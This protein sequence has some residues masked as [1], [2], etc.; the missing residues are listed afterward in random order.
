VGERFDERLLEALADAGGGHFRFLESVDRVG[1]VMADE[2]EEMLS[3]SVRD[4]AVAVTAPEGVVVE[5]LDGLPVSAS[6]G[7]L[8]VS[9]GDLVGDQVV[10]LVLQLRFP[11]GESG[12]S[13][14]VGF[15]L[16]DRGELLSGEAQRSWTWAD[17]AAND[18]QDRDGEVD[19]AV[20]RA[21]AERARAEAL[22]LNASGDLRGGP[23][24]LRATAR[25]I[26]SYAGRDQELNGLVQTLEAEAEDYRAPLEPMERRERHYG[27][28]R[29]RRG[30]DARGRAQRRP[31]VPDLKEILSSLRLGA[32]EVHQNL[33]MF[34]LTNG[35]TRVPD[36][37]TFAEASTAGTVRVEE[38]SEGGSVPELRVVNEGE[39]PVL[40]LD[41]EELIGAKQNRIVNLTILCPA[42]HT[43]VVPVS[44]VEAGRWS[45]SRPDFMDSRQALFAEARARKTRDVNAALRE[46]G[47]RRTDQQAVWADIET[48]ARHLK[49][50]SR[51]SAMSDMYEQQAGVIEGYETAF[52]AAEG[53][54]GAL[55]AINGRAVGLDL[56]DSQKA[57][58]AFLPKLVR[59]YALDALTHAA[60]TPLKAS[61]SDA[62]DLMAT[63]ARTPA[64]TFPAVGLGVDVRLESETVAGAALAVDGR[65][66]HL[67]AFRHAADA[68][69]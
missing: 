58:E 11:R 3:V 4:A 17:H 39:R 42:R 20:A 40:L 53:Q 19:R 57:L 10:S 34:P 6:G 2:L 49:T 67:S 9:L 14:S 12:H 7:Q 65:L 47:E 56:F 63:V 48:K 27:G 31:Q 61:R 35:G 44:C 51:T 36:Y 32:E 26:Q 22:A 37:Q 38:V 66:V 21:F 54:V 1:Q 33:T 28:Y 59:S 69:A 41:G 5:S 16:V 62:L 25:R 15:R 55:F 30:R 13:A 18:H 8:R 45:H 23:A 68:T 64:G 43:L 60:S 50:S 52:S 24:R 29:Q 46:R